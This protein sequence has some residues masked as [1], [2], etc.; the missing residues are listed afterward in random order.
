MS[1]QQ[2][3]EQWYVVHTK[4]QSERYVTRDLTERAIENYCPVFREVRQWSDRVKTIDRPVFPGYIFA[5]F[6]D[7]G[8]NRLQI[9]KSHGAVRILGMQDKPEPVPD[10]EIEAIRRVVDSA[11]SCYAHPLLREGSKVRVKRGILKGVEGRLAR[12]KGQTRLVL[13]VELLGRGISTEVDICDVEILSGR[14]L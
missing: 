3:N 8:R 5:R 10:R 11:L 2:E 14:T 6:Q 13:A 7:C 1:P 9:L 4:S 12:I